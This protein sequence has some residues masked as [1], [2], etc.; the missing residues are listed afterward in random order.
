MDR[1][2]YDLFERKSYSYENEQPGSFTKFLGTPTSL[3]AD[4]RGQVVY[5]WNFTKL[6]YGKKVRVY[7]DVFDKVLLPSGEFFFVNGQGDGRKTKGRLVMRKSHLIM[8][9]QEWDVTQWDSFS[10]FK[11]I[12]DFSAMVDFQGVTFAFLLLDEISKAI[13]LVL[14][15]NCNI[16]SNNVVSTKIRWVSDVKV[17]RT[18]KDILI[19]VVG[20]DGYEEFMIF[21]E[22]TLRL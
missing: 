2:L 12:L 3:T 11:K 16:R 6:Q 22:K 20:A 5:A 21:K 8:H 14:D 18:K 4:D 10:K 19:A 1:T 13:C 17:L 15:E 7:F 9:E